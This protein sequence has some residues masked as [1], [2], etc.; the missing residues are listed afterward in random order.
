MLD[1]AS[2]AYGAC[3][4]W[5]RDAVGLLVVLLCSITHALLVEDKQHILARPMPCHAM[6]GHARPSILSLSLSLSHPILY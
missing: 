6:P 1:A 5:P 2:A 3:L 4:C